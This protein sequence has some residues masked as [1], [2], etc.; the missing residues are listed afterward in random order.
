M[1][2]AVDLI[3]ARSTGGAHGGG[4]RRSSGKLRTHRR[5]IAIAV[6]EIGSP[7]AKIGN[8]IEI[9]DGPLIDPWTPITPIKSP[10]SMLPLSPRKM[11]AGC[12]L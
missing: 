8:R 1:R 2:L 9:A 5:K 7:I 4:R 6:S 11:H 12:Q 10:M 3:R